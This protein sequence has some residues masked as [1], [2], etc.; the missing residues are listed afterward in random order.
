MELLDEGDTLSLPDMSTNGA[1][2]AAVDETEVN[3]VD[4]PP[5]NPELFEVAEA[6]GRGYNGGKGTEAG[7]CLS[8]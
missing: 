2:L 6:E 3:V 5:P 8:I 1:L 4:E 7:F